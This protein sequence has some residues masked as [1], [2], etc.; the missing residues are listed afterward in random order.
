MVFLKLFSPRQLAGIGR[1]KRYNARKILSKDVCIFSIVILM[2]S[3][4]P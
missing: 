1:I 4:G 3:Q 2:T